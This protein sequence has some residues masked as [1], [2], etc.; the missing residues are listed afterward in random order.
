MNPPCSWSTMWSVPQHWGLR[1]CLLCLSPLGINEVCIR[2]RYLDQFFPL[3]NLNSDHHLI[4]QGF[5]ICINW[6]AASYWAS[7]SLVPIACITLFTVEYNASAPCF[8]ITVSSSGSSGAPENS[9]LSDNTSHR[10]NGIPA[11]LWLEVWIQLLHSSLFDSPR[12]F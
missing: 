7:S 5:T 10:V 8:C 9:P 1:I 3:A 4:D 2:L 12:C 6:C 11:L